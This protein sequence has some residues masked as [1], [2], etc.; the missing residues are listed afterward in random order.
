MV[1]QDSTESYFTEKERGGERHTHTEESVLIGYNRLSD[2]ITHCFSDAHELLRNHDRHG[3][4]NTPRALTPPYWDR[5]LSQI[6]S[7]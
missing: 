4:M 2:H 7:N 1:L 5:S 6:T 3:T